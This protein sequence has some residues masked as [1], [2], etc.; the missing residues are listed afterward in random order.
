VVN[1]VDHRI[2]DGQNLVARLDFTRNKITSSVGS[3]INTNGLGADSITNRDVTNA[4]P[5]SNRTNVTGMVQLM[6]VVGPQHVNELRVQAAREYRPWDPGVGPEVTVRDGAPFQTL[7]IYGPQATGLSYGNVGYKFDDTRYQ[8][9]DSLS[10]VSGAHTLKAGFDANLVYSRVRFDPGSNGIY[11]FDGLANYL[12][13]RPAQYTQFAGSGSV[14]TGKHQIAVYLQDEWRA[15]P[16]FTISPGFRYEMALLPDYKTATVPDSRYPLA[17]SIPDDKEMIGPRLGMAWDTRQDGKTVVRAAAGMFYAPPYITLW[18][19]ALVSNGG[20]PELSSTVNLASTAEILAAFGTVGI[21]LAN[22][23]LNNLPVFSINQLNQLRSPQSRLSQATSVFYFDQ[24]FRLPRSVQFRG[25]I[26]HQLTTGL[27][28]SIDY[29]Q[30]AVS[31]MDR[32]RDINLPAPTVDATGRAVYTPSAAVS[33]NSL[34]PDPKFGAVYVTE[35]SARSLY[36]GMTAMM[37]LRR[38]NFLFDASYT[39]GFSQSHDDHENGGFSSA[40]YVDVN[41]LANGVVYLPKGI[42]VATQMRYNSGRPFSPRTGVDSNR[43]GIL[44]DR[45]MLNGKVLQRNEGFRKN[46]FADTSMRVQKNFT[47]PSE[48]M[49]AIT[50]EFFNIFNAA[51]M[52]TNQIT[53]GNDLSQPSTNP[54]F[55]QIRDASGNPIVGNTLRTTPF[56]VQLGLRLQF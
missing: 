1:R 24:D 2:T 7:A 17:T 16:G 35:S 55:N 49:I 27:T 31:R 10:F 44:N 19:Q 5:T 14:D 54:L 25:A 4:A 8:V 53:Y 34:R 18:E 15:F 13:R 36:R 48:K 21:D 41:D 6:S 51:N 28:A 29:T 47:L 38:T 43:D 33:I 12:A 23:P 39:L 20:N 52:E 3:F 32:V 45:P 9:V 11:R 37:N 26:E 50:A 22:A 46:G 30:I 56:Q 42:Q 40:N